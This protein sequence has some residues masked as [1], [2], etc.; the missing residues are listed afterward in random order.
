MKA[1]QFIV[2][3]LALG[4][5]A[6]TAV[7][8]HEPE[9]FKLKSGYLIRWGETEA[10][11]RGQKQGASHLLGLQNNS[12]TIRFTDSHPLITEEAKQ[13]NDELRDSTRNQGR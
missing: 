2:G 3:V 11:A 4:L 13:W 6:S 5:C 12:Q 10:K 8:G 1:P 9:G 7:V